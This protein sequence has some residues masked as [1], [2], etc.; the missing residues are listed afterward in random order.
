MP[1]ARARTFYTR[2]FNLA[3]CSILGLF[4][5]SPIGCSTNPA[6]GKR[7]FTMYSW[8]W[9]K[10]VG[11]EAANGLAEQFGGEVEDVIPSQYVRDVGMKLVQGIE[12]GVPE[13]E[14]EFTLLNSGVINAFALPGGKI[15]FTRGLA[16]KLESEAAMAGVL[17]H[18]IGHVTARHGNQKM[19]QQFGFNLGLAASNVIIGASDS[20]SDLRKYGQIIV[21]GVA[22]G[23]N[24]LLLSYGRGSENEADMLGMRYMERAGYNPVGQLDVMEVLLAS[25]SGARQPEFLSTHPYPESRIEDI[26]G[27]LS[28][29]YAHTQGNSAY[30]LNREQYRRKMLEPLGDLPPAADTQ[31]T[32]SMLNNPLHHSAL[33]CS[34]CTERVSLAD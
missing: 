19:S 13:L 17:G 26:R 30:V 14:W 34:H 23:G 18:E 21:P 7:S 20:D 28:S 29:T 3:L 8:D 2:L 6:T 24:V 11:A 12:P 4:M 15:F 27:L 1:A 5:L 16:E 33:W 32:T 9:E 31:T 10:R 22:I 25:S